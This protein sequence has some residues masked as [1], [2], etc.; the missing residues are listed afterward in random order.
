MEHRNFMFMLA[1]I[2]YTVSN[3]GTEEECTQQTVKVKLITIY[4]LI[5]CPFINMKNHNI[6]NYLIDIETCGIMLF[7]CALEVNSEK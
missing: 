1:Y 3:I 6:E 4:Q 5:E 7:L 2:T